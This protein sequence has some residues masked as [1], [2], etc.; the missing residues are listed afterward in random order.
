MQYIYKSLIPKEAPEKNKL[1]C[2]LIQGL[3]H[4]RHGAFKQQ[5]MKNCIGSSLVRRRFVHEMPTQ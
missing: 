4:N 1:K 5:E 3:S 2:F